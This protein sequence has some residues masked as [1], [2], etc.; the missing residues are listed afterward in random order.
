VYHITLEQGQNLETMFAVLAAAL[1]LTGLIYRRVYRRLGPLRWGLLLLL[2]TV[3]IVVAV[4]LLFRPVCVFEKEVVERRALVLVADSS[5]SM[6]TTDDASGASRFEQVRSRIAGWWGPLQKDFDLHLIEFAGQARPLDGPADL[7]R[8][9][10]NGPATSLVRGLEAAGRKARGR[11]VEGVVLFSDGIHNAAGDP[12]ARARQLGLVVH[13]VGVGNSLRGSPTFRDIRVAGVECPEQLPINNQARIK[14][15]VESVGLD[16][17]LVKVVLEEDGKPISTIELV[18]NGK[19]GPQEAA[20]EFLPRVRGRH[21]YTV[22][23]PPVP[24]EKIKENN[25]RSASAQV[26]DV[27]L[28]V[29]YVEGTLRAEFG[30]LVD[31]FLAKDPDVEFCALIRTR[32]EVFVKRSNMTGLKLTGLPS[33]A[34][35]LDQFDVFVLG[36]LDSNCL[37]PEQMEL[38]KK[39]VRAGAGLLMIGGYHSLGPGGY[40]G[41]PLEDVLPVLVGSR[42]VGQVTEPFLPVLTADGR[43]HPIFANIAAFFP[44]PAPVPA[45]PGLPPLQGCVKVAR[46]KPGASTLAVCPSAAGQDGKPLPV[47]AV[48]AFGKGRAAVFTGDTTRA[49]QQVPHALDQKSP[50]VRFWGQM[51]RWLA[52]RGDAV[53]SGIIA[54]TDKTYYEPDGVITIHAVVRDQEGEGAKQAK[55]VARIKGPGGV[56]ATVPLP[57]LPGPVGNYAATFQPK[58]TGTYEILVE[59]RLGGTLLKA[60]KL[61][62]EVGRSNLEFDKLDLDD[63]MLGRIAAETGGRYFH[64]SMADRLLD[65]LN[66][67]AQRRHMT[68]EQ[69]LYWPEWYWGVFVL[70]LVSE[71]AL[72]RRYQLR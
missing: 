72:R 20:F 47:L 39:R 45:N 38:L 40:G 65:R 56:T 58:A 51:V 57:V 25:H 17:R 63:R 8:V 68:E 60:G 5:A 12:V 27:R 14:G 53:T 22:R 24:E 16:G 66:R 33:T 6:R 32:P 15:L 71:W 46:A 49:W 44:G 26:V 30:A 64:I 18:L 28:R 67:S 62:V 21:T 13:T 2:R 36:D 10:P 61:P 1:L 3:A 54:R 11:R 34:A 69:P 70:V 7:E 35:Q 48:H 9:Q 50:F 29:L 37:K 59:A 52:N 42:D 23:V 41:T 19:N 43:P 4:L 31:R 55:V